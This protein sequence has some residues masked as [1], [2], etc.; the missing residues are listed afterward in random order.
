M[1][2]VSDLTLESLAIDTADPEIAAAL[3]SLYPGIKDPFPLCE[4]SLA[5]T[6]SGVRAAVANAF[7]RVM[8]QELTGHY[9]TAEVESMDKT[10]DRFMKPEFVIFLRI[11]QIPLVYGLER[12]EELEFSVDVTNDTRDVMPVHT[13][14]MEITKGALSH[15]VFNPTIE[16]ASLQ[17]GMRLVIDRVTVA[18]GIGRMAAPANVSNRGRAIPLDLERLPRER[19]HTG[20]QGDAQLSGYV[21]PSTLAKPKKFRVAVSIP[22]AR[23]GSTK[24][25]ELPVQA[26]NNILMRLRQAGEVVER[27]AAADGAAPVAAVASDISSWTVQAADS[28][29]TGEYMSVGTLQLRGETVT[30]TELL[31]TELDELRPDL[32]YVGVHQG[33]D[34]S[35]ISVQY[36]RRCDPAE[37]QDDMMIAIKKLIGVFTSLRGQF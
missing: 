32:S 21:V 29:A 34:L 37:L 33:A 13:G 18:E 15:P 2:A 10:T 27:A 36:S 14:D 16:I 9:L 24:A 11:H 22:A 7:Q 1:A 20:L 19:T 26:C 5:F 3:A 28:P 31:R 23:R 12:G 30:I 4:Q 35:T 25:R 6:L 8:T 17:P